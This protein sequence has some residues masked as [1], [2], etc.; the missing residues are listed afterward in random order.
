MTTPMDFSVFLKRLWQKT[1][2]LDALLLVG[3]AWKAPQYVQPLVGGMLIGLFYLFSLGISARSPKHMAV[4]IAISL[5]RAAGLGYLILV[6]GHF[7][8]TEIAVVLGGFLS[9]KF[10]WMLETGMQAL[11]AFGRKKTAA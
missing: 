7:R 9:Y 10:A 1:L 5:L 2:L 3:C 11:P 4:Q 8:M 6:A